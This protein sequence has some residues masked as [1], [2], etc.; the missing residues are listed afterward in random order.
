MTH[1][2]SMEELSNMVEIVISKSGLSASMKIFAE[3]AI[4]GIIPIDQMKRFLEQNGVVYGIDDKLLEKICIQPMAYNQKNVEI[5]FGT[6]PINGDDGYISWEITNQK[7]TKPKE[8]EDGRVDFYA[9]NQITNIKKGQLIAKRIPGK[10]GTPGKN[11][12][13]EEIPAKKGKDVYFKLG[14]NVVLDQTKD[15]LYAA[16][17]GQVVMTDQGKIN[18]FPV[19]E[20]NGDVDFSIG[21]IDFVGNV[22][23]RGSVPDG[24]RIHAEGDIHVYG[25]VEGAELIA[26]GNI[27]IN[28]G[29]VGHHKSYV[30]AGGNIKASFILDGNAHAGQIIE[31]SQ[32]IMHSQV[33][34]G[35]EVI[36][37]GLKGI[38]VGGKV[39]A[40]DK[41]VA[42][43]IGNQ[44]ATATHL[45]V[46][47]HPLFRQEFNQ[48]KKEKGE[49]TETL[50]KVIKGISLLERME[51]EGQDLSADKKI[52]KVRLKSQEIEINKKL[53]TVT[54]REK[55]IEEEFKSLEH[56][57]IEAFKTIYPGVKLMIGKA[58]KFIQKETVH[59]KFFLEEGVVASR[60]L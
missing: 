1:Q 18:V 31:V 16:I 10:E 23:I 38:I 8:L 5:A 49:L 59:M 21:N 20:V 34:A 48:L 12:S 6:E 4:E 26:N 11:V 13:G 45:E 60:S 14:K 37:K 19:Y 54:A 29:L 56:A 3:E 51:R 35:K 55:E 27:V 41:I 46:G 58:V 15:L 50:D 36:C 25:N 17:D 2:I 30:K 47:I 44:M 9:I 39:Q 53:K 33:S 42:T 7:E 40:G 52:L 43:T 22:V 24:F 32:S 57:S 28:Q